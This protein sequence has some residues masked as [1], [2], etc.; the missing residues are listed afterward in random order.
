MRALTVHDPDELRELRARGEF[1][2][3][4]LANPDSDALASVAKVLDLHDL[5]L[6]DTQEFGQRPKA[7]SYPHEMLL[8]YFGARTQGAVNPEPVE[9]HVH[10]SKEFVLTV[11]REGRE[12]LESVRHSL[13]TRPPETGQVLVYRVLDA[14]TD[15]ILEV[16]DKVSERVGHYEQEIVERPRARDRDEMAALRRS[17]GSFRRML[18]TQRQVLG[19]A[20]ERLVALTDDRDEASAYYRDIGDHLWRASDD[21]DMARDSLQSMVDTYSNEVQERLTIVATIFLP[22]TV[23]AGLFGMNFNWMINHVGSAWAFW[24]VG[25]GGLTASGAAIAVWLRR[26]GLYG[27]RSHSLT[28]RRQRRT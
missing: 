4:D 5:A 27:G 3:L 20:T 11:N 9:V 21:I 24:G 28:G 17:L 1:F 8:V 7:D 23:L 19:R 14:L 25:I 12:E 10:I 2:W 22:L 6:E 18:M 13:E 15:S 26:S 16:M